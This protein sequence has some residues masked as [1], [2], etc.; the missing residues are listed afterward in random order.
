[1]DAPLPDDLARKLDWNLL[2]MFVVLVEA[3][4]ITGAAQELGLQQPSVSSALKRL[5]DTLGRQLIDRSPGWFRVTDAGMALYREAVDIHGA[6]LRFGVLMRDVREE[7]TGHVTIAMAS[8]VL[9]PLFDEALSEFHRRHPKATV[10]IRIENSPTVVER[11]LSRRAS[12]GIAIVSNPHPKLVHQQMYREYFG[13]YC[14]PDHPLFGRKGLKQKDIAGYDWVSF[15]TDQ[16]SDVLRP[17]TILRAQA[18]PDD[19]VIGTAENLEEVRRMIVAGLG[20]GPLPVH[21][22]RP[23]V[24]AGNLFRLPPY[25]DPPEIDV[26]TM[27]NPAMKQNRAEASFNAILSDAISTTPLADRTYGD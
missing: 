1:M 5:E 13:L 14:G 8:H 17:I 21:V 18:T 24:E 12:L 19:R 7:I 9:S 25:R 16:L 26:F 27:V 11:V 10:E 3:G 20:I 23:D 4:S 2:R 6:I 22:A 15:T